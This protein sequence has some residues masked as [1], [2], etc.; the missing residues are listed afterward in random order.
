[1]EVTQLIVDKAAATRADH[2]EAEVVFSK[3]PFYAESGGQVGDTGQLLDPETRER[4]AVVEG[5]YKPA[6][7]AVVQKIR[8]LRPIKP[9]DKLIGVVDKPSRGA[10]MRN[11]TATHLLQA[12][13]RQVSASTSNK[14]AASLNPAASVLI[15]TTT[16]R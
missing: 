13:L 16:P 15:S 3:T 1:M 11:H 6:P 4:V 10:T 9:G 5:A 8:V 7:T 14:P 2:G 12:A